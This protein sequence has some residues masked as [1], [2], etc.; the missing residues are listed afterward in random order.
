MRTVTSIIASHCFQFN[1]GV[2]K[3]SKAI[4]AI[5]F[6]TVFDGEWVARD[7]CWTS[8]FVYSSP[9]KS[10]LQETSLCE[11]WQLAATNKRNW[12]C[13]FLKTAYVIKRLL[14][15]W[16]CSPGH[17]LSGNPK[18]LLWKLVWLSIFD[19]SNEHLDDTSYKDL[20]FD[21]GFNVK[22]DSLNQTRI[23]RCP[24]RQF[25]YR[26]TVALVDAWLKRNRSNSRRTN[27]GF[28]YALKNPPVLC[29]LNITQL[30]RA[31]KT[32]WFGSS[33]GRAIGWSPVDEDSNAS[34]ITVINT[35]HVT[36]KQT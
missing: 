34:R 25:W 12:Q 8:D 7:T 5:G 4:V 26:A 22:F 23:S 33:S 20:D 19:S 18:R 9:A 1:H 13:W 11:G 29:W 32:I 10:D 30:Y 16:T 31:R 15:Q 36:I 28:F 14:F 2:S 17:G 3:K 35:Q 6:N 24:A 27:A 21:D